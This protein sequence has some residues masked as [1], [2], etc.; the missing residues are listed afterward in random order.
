MNLGLSRSIPNV[1]A[2][3]KLAEALSVRLVDL[4]QP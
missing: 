4:F 2:L 1:K 3:V